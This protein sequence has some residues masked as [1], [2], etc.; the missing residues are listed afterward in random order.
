MATI[1]APVKEFNGVVAGVHFAEGKAE[2]DNEAAIQYFERQGYGVDR[3]AEKPV[4]QKPAGSLEELS[5]PKL[6]EYAKAKG[7]ALGDATRKPDILAAIEKAESPIALQSEADPALAAAIEREAVADK[8]AD[9]A[10][11]SDAVGGLS[12]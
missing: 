10:D 7:I 11:T 5:V 8:E 6:R 12:E 2:T 1:N 3:P 9:E 4:E